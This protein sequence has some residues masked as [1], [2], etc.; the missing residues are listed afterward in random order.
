MDKV[1]RPVGAAGKPSSLNA[2]AH[3]AR[4]SCCSGAF[5]PRASFA[6]LTQHRPGVGLPLCLRQGSEL[7]P[8]HHPLLTLHGCPP[9]PQAWI[10]NFVEDKL[11]ALLDFTV[12]G[13]LVCL[14]CPGLQQW[15]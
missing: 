1:G 6:A 14:F 15:G 8:T 4:K 9:P 11:K 2:A 10:P 12:R 7:P 3:S 5:P 13:G